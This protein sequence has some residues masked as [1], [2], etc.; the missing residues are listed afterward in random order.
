MN[1]RVYTMTARAAAAEKTATHVIDAMLDRF[2]RL[3]YD[4]IRLDDVAADAGVTVQTVIRRFGSKAELMR[5]TFERELQRIAAARE[6][7]DSTQVEAIL[8]DL[9]SHYETHGSLI[10]KSYAEG[11]M[12]DGLAPLIAA[13]RDYH[14]SWCRRTFEPH[15]DP[16]LD[17]SAHE[18][19]LAQVTA[20]CDATTWRIL[21]MDAGLD[22]DQT[23]LALREMVTPL[24]DSQDALSG[25]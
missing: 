6:A 3:P 15:I 5:S 10:L 18:R 25:G 22:A 20:I 16:D 21:R 7:G 2:G 8:T 12:V 19:R 4:Q 11:G 24:L 23:S 1:T 14:L 13:G 9:V 17:A